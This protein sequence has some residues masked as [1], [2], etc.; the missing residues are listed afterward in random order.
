MRGRLPCWQVLA[1]PLI[2]AACSGPDAEVL[3]DVQGT[4]IPPVPTLDAAKVLS[5]RRSYDTLCASCHGANGVGSTPNWKIP[6]AQG[7]FPPPPHND[8]GHTWHH[9][10]RVIFE[11][12]RDGIQDTLHPAAPLRMPAFG[13]QLSA[14]QIQAVIS[15]F[16]SLWLKDHQEYQWEIDLQDQTYQRTPAPYE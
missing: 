7:N 1:L 8:D 13:N 14:V 11:I 4:P 10:D 9:S 12:I 2:L 3:R 5:G 15:Y 6:D 16:K